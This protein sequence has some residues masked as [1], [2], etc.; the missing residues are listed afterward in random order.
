MRIEF[1]E[2]YIFYLHKYKQKQNE[3]IHVYTIDMTYLGC[4]ILNLHVIVEMQ[5][6]KT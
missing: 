2:I 6:T 1:T 5:Q 3:E 4:F